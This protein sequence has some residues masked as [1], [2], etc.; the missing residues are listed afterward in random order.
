MLKRFRSTSVEV[1]PLR[2]ISIN[3]ASRAQLLQMLKAVIV[4]LNNMLA[5]NKSSKT[6]FFILMATELTQAMETDK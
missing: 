3:R 1:S 2:I 6:G 4:W 5:N